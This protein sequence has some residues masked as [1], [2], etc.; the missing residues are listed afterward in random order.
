VLLASTGLHDLQDHFRLR[1]GD[2]W[3]WSQMQNGTCITSICDYI[4]TTQISSFKSFRVCA[5]RYFNSDHCML[6]AKLYPG[7]RQQQRQYIKSKTKYP[8]PIST[9]TNSTAK[10][11]FHSICQAKPKTPLQTPKVNDWI[12]AKTYK[13]ICCKAKARKHHSMNRFHR[14]TKSLQRSLR[15]DRR[16]RVKQAAT[17]LETLLRENQI[18]AAYQLL[19]NWY[20]VPKPTST[21]P[22]KSEL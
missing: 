14:L 18:R 8:L 19:Q 21:N 7:H 6:I 13:L 17:I 16:R 11:L 1:P 12:S 3:T 5:P 10:S 20:C 4:M 2:R 15:H 9:G 22:T